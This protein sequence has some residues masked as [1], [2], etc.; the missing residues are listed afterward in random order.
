MVPFPPIKGDSKMDE[1]D[2]VQNLADETRPPEGEE[3]VVDIAE[4]FE[5]GEKGVTA[6]P[7]QPQPG[8]QEPFRCQTAFLCYLDDNG[9]WIA[10]ETLL[11]RMLIMDRP[12]NWNDYRHAAADLTQDLLA[13][14]SAVRATNFMMNAQQQ[15]MANLVAQREA[16]DIAAQTGVGGGVDLSTLK[17]MAA[18]GGKGIVPGR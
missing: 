13:Q 18:Q 3:S 17:R 9:H 8:P 7:E 12:A 4:A 10:D 1:G 16:A 5:A 14:E 6:P 15:A 2:A 11:D